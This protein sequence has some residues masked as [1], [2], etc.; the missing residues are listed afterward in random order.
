MHAIDILKAEVAAGD[1]E[2]E[3]EE[4]KESKWCQHAK[5]YYVVLE[6]YWLSCKKMFYIGDFS[7]A[8]NKHVLVYRPYSLFLYKY[9]YRLS[10]QPHNITNLSNFISKS[11]IG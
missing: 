4:K 6:F 3:L 1:W 5:Y 8:R 10:N 7:M 9:K 2:G 11:L